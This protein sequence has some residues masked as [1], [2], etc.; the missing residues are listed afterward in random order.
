MLIPCFTLPTDGF[1]TR[2]L[3]WFGAEFECL[4]FL[5]WTTSLLSTE[6]NHGNT[7]LGSRE[8]TEKQTKSA[9]ETNSGLIN[10]RIK[11]KVF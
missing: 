10:P 9:P 7:F 1:L 4:F 6:N 2:G 3:I 11:F 8:L 5:C